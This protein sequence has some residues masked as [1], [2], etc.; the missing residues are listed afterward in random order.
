MI[1]HVVDVETTGL[2]PAKDR[3]VELAAVQL[4]CLEDPT[5]PSINPFGSTFVNPRCAIPPEVTAV[6][7]IIELDVAGAPDL[8]EAIDYVLTPFW[9]E[10][11]DIVAAHN[12]RFDRD[13]L[14]PLKDKRWVDT[15]R[16][17]LHLWPDAPSFKNA[18]LYYWRGFKRIEPVEAH[19][20]S[21][22]ALLTAHILR[23]M[24]AE[25][26]VDELLRLSTK[27]ALLRKVKFGKHAGMLWAEVPSD[28]LSWAARQDF[29]DADV[30]F[31]VKSEMA[32]RAKGE[33]A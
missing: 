3:V 23:E 15:Y 9:R 7:H 22:D 33:T 28:Y 31:T 26:T 2:D 17:A 6:H 27:A 25:R 11:V 4:L 32:R 1:I 14:P 18:A 29:D 30:K 21:Y 5:L 20:A 13:F 10:T 12:A 16:C 19:R 8:G 24:L